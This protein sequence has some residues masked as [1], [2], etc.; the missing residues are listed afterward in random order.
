MSRC[1]EGKAK[2]MT[3]DA[4]KEEGVNRIVPR[5]SS[6][7]GRG[8]DLVHVE[9]R[10]LFPTKKNSFTIG[11]IRSPGNGLVPQGP[12]LQDGWDQV[13]SCQHLRRHYCGIYCS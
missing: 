6:P 10:P 5:L 2:S 11:F 1:E 3:G 12:R 4:S 9:T 7:E 13:Q 8:E